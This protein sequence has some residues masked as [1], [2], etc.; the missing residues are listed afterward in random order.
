MIHVKGFVILCI[1][2]AIVFMLRVA[3]SFTGG[4]HEL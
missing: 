1:V 3:A 4:A 2:V